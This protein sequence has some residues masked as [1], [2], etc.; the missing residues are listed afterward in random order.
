MLNRRTFL[1]TVA[2]TGVAATFSPNAL[3]VG[4]PLPF[5]KHIAEIT[6]LHKKLSHE[7]PC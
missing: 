2:L 1:H 6:Y 4:L 5:R 7:H 3:L